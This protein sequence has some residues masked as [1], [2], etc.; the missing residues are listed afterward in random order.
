MRLSLLSRHSHEAAMGTN[1]QL[2]R[3]SLELQA[4]RELVNPP[5]DSV[6]VAKPAAIAETKRVAP[7]A[8]AAIEQAARLWKVRSL[9]RLLLLPPAIPS[10]A[11]RLLSHALRLDLGPDQRPFPVRRGHELIAGAK[12]VAIRVEV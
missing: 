8:I 1:S 10:L 3:I 11:A 7:D 9:P 2:D 6:Q 4:W 12:H 5:R